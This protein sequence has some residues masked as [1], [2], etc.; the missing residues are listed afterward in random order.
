M[1]PHP[2]ATCSKTLAANASAHPLDVVKMKSALGALG[3][4]AAPDWG[5]SQ[6]PDA[7]LFDA[8]KRFQKSQG[9]KTDGAI[10]PGG[11]TEAALSQALTPRRATTALQATA[12]AIQKM[13]RGGDELLAHITREE[14]ALLNRATDGA[15]IN[16]QT[17]LLEFWYDYEADAAG[18]GTEADN[19]GQDSYGSDQ[20]NDGWGNPIDDEQDK[21]P[22]DNGQSGDSENGQGGHSLGGST[23]ASLTEA[24]EQAGKAKG[25][26]N[27]GASGRAQSRSLTDGLLDLNSDPN[28]DDED[29]LDWDASLLGEPEPKNAPPADPNAPADPKEGSGAGNASG[30]GSWI[31]NVS[32]QSGYT[33]T[34]AGRIEDGYAVSIVDEN[35]LGPIGKALE[36][37]WDFVAD[38]HDRATNPNLNTMTQEQGAIVAK[39]I[40]AIV[41]LETLGGGLKVG[42]AIRKDS[43]GATMDIT[44]DI[45]LDKADKLKN[46]WGYK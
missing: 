15:S 6:F 2:I 41:T 27:R 24:K 20:D 42:G 28:P 29:A 26:R 11:E 16:P 12:Q 36:G 40:G 8:I 38:I 35:K 43:L 34:P 13:G 46:E 32:K 19:R 23:S 18:V 22:D 5:V 25:Q 31:S 14:A 45:L 44:G 4:Y 9:L 3:H 33:L 17:G 30:Q 37:I 1:R 39:E 21:S 10:K 7:A